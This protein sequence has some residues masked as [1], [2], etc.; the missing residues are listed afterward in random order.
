MKKKSRIPLLKL[1]KT[2]IVE[3]LLKI[4]Q[5][6]PIILNFFKWATIPLYEDLDMLKTKLFKISQNGPISVNL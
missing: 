2:K 3:N 5:N 6:G 4:L 1:P